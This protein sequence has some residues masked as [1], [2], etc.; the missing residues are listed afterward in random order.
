MSHT[1]GKSWGVEFVLIF[2][3]AK[4]VYRVT[5]CPS[6]EAVNPWHSEGEEPQPPQKN[7]ELHRVLASESED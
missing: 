2:S 1:P 6:L 4:A 7:L 5:G 3:R